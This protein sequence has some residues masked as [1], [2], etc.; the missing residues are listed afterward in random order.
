[1]TTG[2]PVTG[3]F[4]AMTNII[5]APGGTMDAAGNMVATLIKDQ[6]A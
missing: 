2:L 5:G 4:D 6:R 1:M 3:V